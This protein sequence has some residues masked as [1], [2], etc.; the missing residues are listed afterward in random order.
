MVVISVKTPEHYKL[1][2][3]AL[4]AKKDLFVEWPLAANLKQAK[5]LTALAKSQN[6]KTIIGLQGRQAPSVLK[7]K[8]MI[9]AGKLGDILGTTVS[10]P[11][12]SLIS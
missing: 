5:E 7:A 1:A 4:E 11:S 6:V 9:A 12:S 8:E 10:L 3:P 2:K